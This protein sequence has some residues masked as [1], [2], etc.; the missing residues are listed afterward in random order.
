MG[1]IGTFG[2]PEIIVLLMIFGTAPGFWFI[3]RRVGRNPWLSLIACFF[4]LIGP[5]ALVYYV[6]FARW[7]KESPSAGNASAVLPGKKSIA[8]CGDCHV[9]VAINSKFCPNC[10]AKFEKR[11]E[12]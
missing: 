11:V 1:P 5:M 6:A 8:R 7:P 2:L 3:L 10:G 12:Q 9:D 4:P